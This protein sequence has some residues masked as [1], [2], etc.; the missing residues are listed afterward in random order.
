MYYKP[1][2][3]REAVENVNKTWLLPAIQRPYD[4]G[5]RSRKEQFIHKL[6]DSLVRR[7]PIGTLIIWKTNQKV[8]FRNFLEDYD[9]EKLAKIMD[10]GLWG[11][12]DKHLVYDGQQRLQSLYSCLKYTFHNKVLCYDLLFDPESNK[13]AN[14]FTFFQRNEDIEPRFLKMNELYSHNRKQEAE[15][16]EKVLGRFNKGIGDRERLLVKSNFRRLWNLFV[17]EDIKLLSYYPLEIDLDE[18]EVLDIFI[19]INT[20]GMQLTKSEILFSKIKKVQFDFEERIWETCFRIKKITNGYSVCPDDVL[21]VLFLLVKDTVRVEPDR[22]DESELNSFVRTWSKLESP[23]CS[24]FHDFLYK[25][26]R[27]NRENIVRSKEP[28]LPLIVYFYYMKSIHNCRFRDFAPRSIRNMKKYL[29]T[30]QLKYWDYQKFVDNFHRIIRDILTKKTAKKDP[31]FP[32]E[33]LRKLVRE[34]GRRDTDLESDDFNIASLRWFTLK[35]LTP[36][37]EYQYAGDPNERFN[38]EIDHIFPRT[39]ESEREYP[40]KYYKWSETI[41]NLQPVK[42]EINGCKR[43]RPPSMFFPK[44][45]EYLKDYDFLPTKNLRNRLWLDKYAK[46]FIQRRKEKMLTFAR[47]EYG[48]K[49]R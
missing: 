10:E 5:E 20:T 18:D 2:S 48:L 47:K 42:G 44:Y 22:V 3:V 37:R 21:K 31:V 35:I 23:L 17:E 7:Y 45:P 6:F 12:A 43:N 27:I 14:G 26:F 29:I 40:Q 1:I 46:E 11:K 33:K 19:R 15:Y 25:G 28:L 32:F 30:S 13:R 36:Q 34:D 9:S 16:E 39:P 41:W 8:P 4:W 24:F 38:P 49:I